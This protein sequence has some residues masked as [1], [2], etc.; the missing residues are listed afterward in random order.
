MPKY[1]LKFGSHSY[2]GVT[3][4]KND[5][6][7]ITEEHMQRFGGEEQF[8]LVIAKAKEKDD[9]EITI[10]DLLL[11][12]IPE[13]EAQLATVNDNAALDAVQVEEKAGKQRAGVF[14]AI[15]ARRKELIKEK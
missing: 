1:K 8:A 6:I 5:E 15:E 10:T 9:D 12:S 3:Y 14:T 2:K 11:K 13:I 7:E 4:H